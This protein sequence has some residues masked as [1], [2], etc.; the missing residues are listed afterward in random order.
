VKIKIIFLLVALCW[1]V[2][3][4]ATSVPTPD[5]AATQVAAEQAVSAT[6]TAQSPTETNTPSRTPTP[7]STHTSTPT[8]TPTSTHTPTP[9]PTHTHTPS[10]TPTLT[11]TSTSSPTSTPSYT[12]SPTLTHT[13][14]PSSTP[15]P[16][17]TATLSPFEIEWE[18]DPASKWW[19]SCSET[20]FYGLTLGRRG[21][22]LGD[23]WIYI[24][25]EGW[26][27]TW[28]Q[29]QWQGDDWNWEIKIDDRPRA[30]KWIIAVTSEYGSW[31]A[32]S[33]VMFVET[34]AEPCEM[35]SGGVQVVYLVLRQK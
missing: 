10:P 14:T 12:P 34:D 32:S 16:T 7:T 22:F 20:R 17:P 28:V 31:D 30:G 3:C 33:F 4:G 5:L 23:K 26:G 27:E 19:S 13:P 11:P 21:G 25:G 35:G 18:L 6:E 1:L 24:R 15:S 9:T 29:T 8:W 2:G